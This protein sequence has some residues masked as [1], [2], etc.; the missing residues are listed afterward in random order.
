[1]PFFNGSSDSIIANS[2]LSEIRLGDI[3]NI[4]LT[5]QGPLRF[6][7]YSRLYKLTVLHL[8]VF[9]TQI[10]GEMKSTIG[11]SLMRRISDV[12]PSSISLL[13]L[14]RPLPPH[15]TL[16]VLAANVATTIAQMLTSSK[17]SLSPVKLAGTITISTHL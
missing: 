1:M 12:V 5:T 13:R 15:L 11:V 2:Y 6:F 10:L 3:F 9:F 4:N 14:V 7:F 8:T 16:R 17:H